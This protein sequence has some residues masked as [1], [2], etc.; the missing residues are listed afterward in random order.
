MKR[1]HVNWCKILYPSAETRD[2]SQ[3]LKSC[4]G[5][6]AAIDTESFI[7]IA[8]VSFSIFFLHQAVF[9]V[10]V[11]CVD[12]SLWGEWMHGVSAPAK[13]QQVLRKHNGYTDSMWWFETCFIVT[14]PGEMIWFDEH[15]CSSG[16]FN[17]Q[18]SY[19]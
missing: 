1:N 15:F 7:P 9:L 11:L 8:R 10:Y 3:E 19:N 13:L 12:T 17:H 2:V 14:L 18:P 16:L 4:I 6:N 5:T